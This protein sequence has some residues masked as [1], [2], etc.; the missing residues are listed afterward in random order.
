MLSSNSGGKK[1]SGIVSVG[2]RLSSSTFGGKELSSRDTAVVRSL[3]V[4]K[5]LGVILVVK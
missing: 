3:A 5:S 4:L 1:L 2:E